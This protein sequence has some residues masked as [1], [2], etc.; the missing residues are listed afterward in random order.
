MTIKTTI[1]IL[2][3]VLF[4]YT[5]QAQDPIFTQSNYIQETLNPGFTGFEDNDRV[6]AGLLSRTQWPNLDLKVSTQYFFINKSYENRNSSGS[7]IGFNAMWQNESFSN[8]NFYQVNINYMHRV[9]LNGGWFFRPALEVGFGLKDV[10]FR[11]LTLADQININ[12]GVISPSSV[13]P[14]GANTENVTFFDVTGGVVFEKNARN[15]NTYWFGFS[16]KHLNR[17]NISFLRDQNVPLDIFY[18]VHGNYRFPFLNDYRIMMTANYMQQGEYNRLD[19]GSLFQVNQFLVGI[20]AATN[21][22]KNDSNS[23]LL[24]SI[25]S[26]IGLEYTSFRFG[27]SYDANISKIGRT[28]GVYEF[29]VTYMSRCRN[30]PTDRSRKR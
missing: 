23:H 29:S 6:S 2:V 8:Y 24:T 5:A 19:I 28:N 26:F 4:G 22:A 27:L 15:D 11:S 13:D 21:P 17:P 20:T 18:S 9:N 25:N 1:S 7:G 14:F 3:V 10:G 16:A 30:C 12:T